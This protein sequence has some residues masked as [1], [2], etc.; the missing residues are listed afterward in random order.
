MFCYLLKI[1]MIDIVTILPDIFN[2]VDS[3]IKVKQ[4]NMDKKIKT[5]APV[6]CPK[7][8][9]EVLVEFT[10]VS[11]ELTSVFTIEDVKSAKIEVLRRLEKISG[12]EAR[13]EEIKTWVEEEG[14]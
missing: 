3:S 4:I 9:C 8:S 13:K 1:K 2:F 10:N 11:P 7:C 5:I 12:N 14:K 6:T